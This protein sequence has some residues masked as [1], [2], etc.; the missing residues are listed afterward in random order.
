MQQLISPKQWQ[1]A[2][3]VLY[4]THLAI[5]DYYYQ[6]TFLSELAKQYPNIELD[7]WID[8]CR[9]RPKSWHAGR[10]QILCQWLETESHINQI[11]PIAA[12]KQERKALIN[13]AQEQQYDIVVFMAQTRTENFA[14]IARQIAPQGYVVGTKTK[15]L[16]KWLKKTIC[17]SK[18]DG[19]FNLEK[20]EKEWPNE[21]I[22]QKYRHIFEQLFSIKFNDELPI[23]SLDI[24]QVHLDKMETWVDEFKSRNPKT[25]HLLLINHLSTNS[26]RDLPWANLIELIVCIAKMHPSYAF[27][28]NLPPTEVDAIKQQVKTCSALHNL[29][30]DIFTATEHFF[31]LPAL[32]KLSDAVITVET[33]VMHLTS[34]LRTPQIVLMREAASHWRP[35]NAKQILYGRSVVG[36]I[37]VSDIIQ[38]FN[39]L[40]HSD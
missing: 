17:F 20:I 3:R 25:S 29:N 22:N 35:I 30:I 8:D 27:I 33:A 16:Q 7:I 12:S 24:P 2:Q 32:L 39:R 6:R 21:H 14:Q 34:G 18:L 5:G 4:M 23:K 11:Y 28:L 9:S 38:T 1:K 19:Y 37:P 15:P 10:N 31:Q 26:R 36:D 13:K 40:S